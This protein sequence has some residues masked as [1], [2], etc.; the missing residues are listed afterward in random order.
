MTDVDELV[1]V[2]TY[3]GSPIDIDLNTDP[4]SLVVTADPE[5]FSVELLEGDSSLLDL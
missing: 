1:E 4:Y 5:D 2:S 3:Q